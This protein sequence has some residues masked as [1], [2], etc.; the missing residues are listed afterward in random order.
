VRDSWAQVSGIENVKMT[1]K[2]WNDST[3][4]VRVQNLRDEEERKFQLFAGNVSPLLTTFYG[5]TIQFDQ[6]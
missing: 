1:L 4:L 6:V 5:N 3:V 2:A